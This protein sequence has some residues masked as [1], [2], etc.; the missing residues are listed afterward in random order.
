MTT[1]IVIQLN[2]V[3]AHPYWYGFTLINYNNQQPF[4]RKLYSDLLEPADIQFICDTVCDNL[5][6]EI[7]RRIGF[8]QGSNQAT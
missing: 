2:Y 3:I 7:D 4:V 6:N 8:I 5:I 1:N